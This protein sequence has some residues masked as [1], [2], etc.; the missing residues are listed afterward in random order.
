MYIGQ[1]VK[2]RTALATDGTDYT[3]GNG[4]GYGNGVRHKPLTPRPPTHG[5]AKSSFLSVN[6]NRPGGPRV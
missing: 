1:Q 4:Y 6:R 3:D 5:P 2:R